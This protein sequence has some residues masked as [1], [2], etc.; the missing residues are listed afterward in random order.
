MPEN[1]TARIIIGCVAVLILAVAAYSLL[2]R[3][4]KVH[5]IKAPHAIKQH[6]LDI[7][8]APK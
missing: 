4:H 1:P 7:Q 5:K 2:P 6:Q 8:A 3:R